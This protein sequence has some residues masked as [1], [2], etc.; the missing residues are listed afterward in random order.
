MAEQ[1]S[2]GT[3]T[4]SSLGHRTEGQG[5]VSSTMW[6]SHDMQKCQR[7]WEW[8]TNPPRECGR[9]ADTHRGAGSAAGWF[10]KCAKA[11]LSPCLPWLSCC[12][13]NVLY[14]FCTQAHSWTGGKCPAG[15]HDKPAQPQGWWR[16]NETL[17][18]AVAA[19]CVTECPST[20]LQTWKG[21]TQDIPALVGSPWVN[22][23]HH[24]H[25]ASN[26]SLQ[27][28]SLDVSTLILMLL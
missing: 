4:R 26:T 21:P 14:T 28:C 17:P 20:H 10:R 13:R 23:N 9:R 11:S 19:L 27:L 12:Y 24:I 16:R 25:G 3:G 8:N 2:Q 18:C 15:Q 7:T 6:C 22:I 5:A 1:L